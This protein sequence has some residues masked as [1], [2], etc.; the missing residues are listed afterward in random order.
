MRQEVW[1]GILAGVVVSVSHSETKARFSGESEKSATFT[2]DSTRAC[3]S[4]TYTPLSPP[5]CRVPP[6]LNPFP[7]VSSLS[8]PLPN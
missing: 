1:W 8:S 3:L 6:L 4:E 5:L 2:R 7:K